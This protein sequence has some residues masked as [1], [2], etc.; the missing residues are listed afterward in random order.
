[1][2]VL[3]TGGAGPVGSSLALLLKRDR[4]DATVYAL[5]NLRRRGS[6]LAINRLRAGGVDFIHGDIRIPDDL[7]DAGPSIFC[8]IAPL[9][10]PSML[11]IEQ[12]R[13]RHPDESRRN[14]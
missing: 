3:V 8:S 11:G 2:R 4:P 5:D 14:G 9:S 6:E 12:P 1:M 10:R 7:A 13:I